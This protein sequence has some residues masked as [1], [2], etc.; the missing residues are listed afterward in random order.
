MEDW[1]VSLFVFSHMLKL[2]L[3]GLPLDWT[4]STRN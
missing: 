2:K 3:S 1:M 4:T